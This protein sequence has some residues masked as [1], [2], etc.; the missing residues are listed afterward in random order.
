MGKGEEALFYEDSWDGHPPIDNMGLPN[1]S[2]ELFINL[3]GS[4]VSDYKIMKSTSDGTKW[5]WKS[6]EKLDIDPTVKKKDSRK[7]IHKRRIKKVD[8]KDNLI[9][10]ASKEGRYSVKEGL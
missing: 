8:R 3:W 9:W 1:S 7:I 6:I 4:K 10:A 2:K 5:E